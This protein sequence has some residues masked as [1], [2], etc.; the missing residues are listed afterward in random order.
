MVYITF[1][2]ERIM[3]TWVSIK[4][5]NKMIDLHK[6]TIEAPITYTNKT[7]YTIPRNAP[8]SQINE[9]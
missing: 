5:D 6:F 4:F 9:N 7:V 3:H 8:I 1:I 2:V